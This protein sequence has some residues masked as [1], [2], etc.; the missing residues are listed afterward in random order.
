[1]VYRVIEAENVSMKA[2]ASDWIIAIAILYVSANRMPHIGRMDT[3]LILPSGLQ[4]IFHQRM[5][6]RAVKDPIVGNGIFSTIVN[7][8]TVCNICFIV[9]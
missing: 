8:R 1:M 6:C 4:T 2:E 9:L 7:R 3:Y 5:A